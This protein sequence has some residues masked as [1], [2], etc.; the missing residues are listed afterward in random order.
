MA[1][2]ARGIDRS[3]FRVGLLIFGREQRIHYQD[4]RSSDIWFR[5]LNIG[6][7]SRK[8]EI[9]GKLFTGLRRAFEDFEPDLI[10]TSLNVANHAV[11]ATALL[12]RADVPIITSVR[13]DF[14][15]GY[16]RAERLAER[17]LS[18]RSRFIVTN[19]PEVRSQLLENLRLPGDRIRVIPN[20]LANEF[21]D[22]DIPPPPTWLPSDRRVLLCVGRF[23][24]QKGQ[25]QLLEA[26]AGLGWAAQ[27]EWHAVLIGEGELEADIQ[28]AAKPLGANVTIRAPVR[29]LRPIYHAATLTIMPSKWE[30]LPNVALEA[31]ASG[32]PVAISRDANRAAV[33]TNETGWE[34]TDDL[35]SILS[36]LMSISTD[37]LRKRGVLAK[38]SVLERFGETRM[39]REY[40]GIYRECVGLVE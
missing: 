7:G 33:V 34:F 6:G 35:P 20:G 28:N 36:H 17:L 37:E 38:S 22:T 39:I 26:L 2:L 23:T 10:H 19:S 18:P 30:G 25:V 16:S 14:Q 15:K 3:K 24:R 8:F 12:S 13:N 11:R 40:E 4:V 21:F 29:D 9:A 31:Q 1:L 5:A 32:C 27:S